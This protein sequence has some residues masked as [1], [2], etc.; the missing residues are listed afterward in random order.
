MKKLNYQILL[1]LKNA[2]GIIE[3]IH[4]IS[5]KEALGFIVLC[6]IVNKDLD[7][8]IEKFPTRL[9]YPSM[10]SILN[11]DKKALDHFINCVKLTPLYL[12][13]DILDFW[14]NYGLTRYNFI[15]E[16]AER[17]NKFPSFSTIP[18]TY[19][20]TENKIK[21]QAFIPEDK[22]T[23]LIYEIVT[24]NIES[25]KKDNKKYNKSKNP[26]HRPLSATTKENTTEF[27]RLLE[28][29]RNG[30]IE[31]THENIK[32][33]IAEKYGIDKDTIPRWLQKKLKL[34]NKNNVE[35]LTSKDLEI[36]WKSVEKD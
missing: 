22:L 5:L 19:S 30:L 10:D 28:K 4:N 6:F 20:N 12:L 11:S 24:K 29:K 8:P 2:I 7:Y 17:A 1:K 34:T 35:D 16:E 15:F 36:I 13:D 31:M 25:L 26:P 27:V 23:K 14:N 33:R 18:P 32:K 9:V 21:N 3:R